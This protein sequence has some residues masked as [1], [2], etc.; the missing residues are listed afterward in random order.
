MS[1]F[2][3]EAEMPQRPRKVTVDRKE[4]P[5]SFS[6]S[7]P[8][9]APKRPLGL[10]RG[11]LDVLELFADPAHLR[12]D[13][14]RPGEERCHHRKHWKPGKRG[15]PDTDESEQPKSRLLEAVGN[16]PTNRRY[17]SSI[18]TNLPYGAN[19]LQS[20]EDPP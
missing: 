9:T 7:R 1:P 4:R 14:R 18:R 20:F 2:R 3:G 11:Q 13:V 17:A 10:G 15:D 19:F 6:L 12:R 16:H 5:G 8:C